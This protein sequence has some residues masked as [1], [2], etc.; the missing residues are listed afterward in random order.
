MTKTIL[1]FGDS[2][3]HGINPADDTRFPKSKRWTTILQEHLRKD[4][5]IIVE[6][7]P[8]RTS[9]VD[10]PIEGKSKN[11]RRYLKPCLD[12]H[13]PIDLVIVMLGTCEMKKRY[14]FTAQDIALSMEHLIKILL[15]SDAGPGGK[16]PEILLLSPIPL[17]PNIDKSPLYKGAA[18]LP[19]EVAPLY[20]EL[21]KRYEFA[22]LET[23]KFVAASSLDGLHLDLES[24]RKLGTAVAAIVNTL[25][26]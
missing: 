11:G 23:G 1:C 8:G 21:A 15:A 2:N 12:S 9:S 22:F 7:L 13:S 5:E 6:G 19:Q 26:S 3:T 24:H 4:F 20:E 18:H 17:A 25:M 14:S 16:A 10:D